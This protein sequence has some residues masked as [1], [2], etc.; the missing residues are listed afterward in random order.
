MKELSDKLTIKELNQ[1]A[2]QGKVSY[3]DHGLKIIG[4]FKYRLEGGVYQRVDK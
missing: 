4:E 3:E 2:L 1:F